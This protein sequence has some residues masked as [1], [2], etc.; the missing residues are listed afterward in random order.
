LSNICGMAV[1]QP[2]N[3]TVSAGQ[4]VIGITGGHIMITWSNPAASL[5]TAPVVTGPWM[6][7]TGA[8]SPYPVNSSAASAFFRLSQ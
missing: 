6:T 3:L 8:S 5:Q 2:I 7:I 4:M 1:S